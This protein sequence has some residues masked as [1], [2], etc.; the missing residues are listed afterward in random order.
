MA[1]CSVLWLHVC[2]FIGCGE[3]ENIVEF[4]LQSHSQNDLTLTSAP[5]TPEFFDDQKVPSC[6]SNKMG[7]KKAQTF[8]RDKT[9]RGV[10]ELSTTGHKVSLISIFYFKLRGALLPKLSKA[11]CAARLD[12]LLHVKNNWPRGVHPV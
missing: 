5:L 12:F 4:W 1:A 10:L 8:W 7:F 9:G 6:Q 2:S 11:L 3:L